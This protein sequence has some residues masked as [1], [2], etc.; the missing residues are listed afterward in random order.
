VSVYETH[1]QEQKEEGILKK[2]Q[3]G[4]QETRSLFH[5]LRQLPCILACN[6]ARALQLLIARQLGEIE[7][8]EVV[9]IL[10]VDNDELVAEISRPTLSSIEQDTNQIALKACHALDRLMH[11]AERRTDSVS[12]R[13]YASSRTQLHKCNSS[14]RYNCVRG[15]SNNPARSL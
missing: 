10:G 3:A 5:W 4:F 11:G 15:T 13:S 12:N 1:G 9:S 6:D 2:I 14:A 8:P 7:V